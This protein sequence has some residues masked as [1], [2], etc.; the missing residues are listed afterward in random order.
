MQQAYPKSI[1]RKTKV[2]FSSFSFFYVHPHPST[3]PSGLR[4]PHISISG[5]RIGSSVF[6]LGCARLEKLFF[7]GLHI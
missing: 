7:L 1:A 6:Q 2:G 4:N 3:Q 5:Q